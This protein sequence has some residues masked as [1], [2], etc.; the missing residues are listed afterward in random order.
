MLT[1]FNVAK[2]LINPQPWFLLGTFKIVA[3]SVLL[4]PFKRPRVPSHLKGRAGWREGQ[5][6]TLCLYIC[7]CNQRKL[8]CNYLL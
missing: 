1:S 7:P 4:L 8:S 6:P 3:K 5:Q 2:S